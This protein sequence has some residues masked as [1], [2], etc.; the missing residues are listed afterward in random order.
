[1]EVILKNYRN[2]NN[3]FNSRVSDL[4]YGLIIQNNLSGNNSFWQSKLGIS[5]NSFD[6]QFQGSLRF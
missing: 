6:A 2:T 3:G 5:G 1:M 4:S